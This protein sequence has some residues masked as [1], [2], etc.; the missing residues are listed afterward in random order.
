MSVINF[1]LRSGAGSVTLWG[2]YL[3]LVDGNV[4][5]S[6]WVHVGFL[7]YEMGQMAKRQR[8]GT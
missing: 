1:I 6:R 4:Q 3:G 2:R 8:D 5:E 7:R